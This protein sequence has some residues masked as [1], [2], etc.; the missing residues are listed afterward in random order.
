MALTKLDLG[1]GA[2]GTVARSILPSGTVVQTVR[3]QLTTKFASSA[4]SSYV[5]IGLSA[6]ITPTASPF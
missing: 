6:A 4:T 1:E 5:D 2:S 3:G